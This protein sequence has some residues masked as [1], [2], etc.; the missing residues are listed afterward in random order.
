MVGNDNFK[1]K[2]LIL[3]IF[4]KTPTSGGTKRVDLR[5]LHS[6]FLQCYTEG[7]FVVAP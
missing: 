7:P 3:D 5:N 6:Q 4:S 2:C 1:V